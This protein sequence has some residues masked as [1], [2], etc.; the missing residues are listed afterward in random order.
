MRTLGA[1]L[2]ICGTAC[3]T[4]PVTVPIVLSSAIELGPRRTIAVAGLRGWKDRP[5]LRGWKDRSS[6]ELLEQALAGTGRFVIVERARVDGAIRSLQLST[7]EPN[8]AAKLGALLG[9]DAVVYGFIEEEYQEAETREAFEG[10]GAITSQVDRLTVPG[11]TYFTKYIRATLRGEAVV[12]AAFTIVDGTSGALLAVKTSEER[13]AGVHQ[14]LITLEPGDRPRDA[15]DARPEALDPDELAEAARRAVLDRFVEALG[16]TEV[17]ATFL[18]D[19]A[20]PQLQAGIDWAARGALRE[21]QVSFQSVISKALEDPRAERKQLAKAYWDLALAQEYAGPNGSNDSND[22]QAIRMLRMACD[23]GKEK[24]C[25]EE[26]ETLQRRRQ[27]SRRLAEW[28]SQKTREASARAAAEKLIRDQE[29]RKA[30]LWSDP[31]LVANARSARLCKL[32]RWRADT[33]SLLKTCSSSDAAAP[34]GINEADFA[35]RGALDKRLQ[36]IDE[37]KQAERA[38]LVESDRTPLPCTSSFIHRLSECLFVSYEAPD[39]T[40]VLYGRSA[41]CRDADLQPAMQLF[42]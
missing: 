22:E 3:R 20:I 35:P 25:R 4:A 27:D 40:T 38:L 30:A 14:K 37:R 15:R 12:R 21:A 32:D 36:A 5:G 1:A 19:L 16:P 2:V 39:Q 18:A 11:Q 42:E 7:L 33:L 10:K 17:R 6:S 8:G 41:I 23:L 9:A 13:R 28:A 29:E 31:V 24:R 34:C 26:L